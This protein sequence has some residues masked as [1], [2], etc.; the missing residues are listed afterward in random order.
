MSELCNIKEIFPP[1][2]INDSDLITYISIYGVDN[3]GLDLLIMLFT[4]KERVC[5]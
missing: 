2:S 4:K 3:S 5:C 1:Q